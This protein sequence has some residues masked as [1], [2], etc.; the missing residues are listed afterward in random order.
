VNNLPRKT[1]D[2]LISLNFFRRPRGAE[3]KNTVNKLCISFCCRV[4]KECYDVYSSLKERTGDGDRKKISPFQDNPRRLGKSRVR[5]VGRA[6]LYRSESFGEAE[7]TSSS[8]GV[9]APSQC[10]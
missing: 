5:L 6:P 7:F 4:T 3:S 1:G 9:R 8:G 10:E 2:T